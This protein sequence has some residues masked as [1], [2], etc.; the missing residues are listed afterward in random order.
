MTKL[1]RYRYIVVAQILYMIKKATQR[2]YNII[3][4]SLRVT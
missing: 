4:L 2:Q 1:N 3:E